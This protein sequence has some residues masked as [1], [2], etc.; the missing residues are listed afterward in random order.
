MFII[1]LH[2]VCYIFQSSTT[3]YSVI[4]SNRVEDW[5]N[6]FFDQDV[7]VSPQ[8]SSSVFPSFFRGLRVSIIIG[9]QV[10]ISLQLPNKFW[11]ST[12][13]V[14]RK[15]R[16]NATENSL[17]R[18]FLSSKQTSPQDSAESLKCLFQNFR[19]MWR[20]LHWFIC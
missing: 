7:P 9:L 19:K 20:T 1:L 4:R 2:D 15:Y 8:Y 11:K 16:I 12:K 14:E 18:F 17:C 6:H 3:L 10:L 13:T 5:D